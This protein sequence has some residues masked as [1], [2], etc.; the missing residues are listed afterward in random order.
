M[1]RKFR[2][3]KDE[4]EEHIECEIESA[5]NHLMHRMY[6]ELR[7]TMDYAVQQHDE[8]ALLE[9]ISRHEVILENKILIEMARN[10]FNIKKEVKK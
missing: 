3:L 6:N 10:A 9:L 1:D 4:L 5:K 2:E 8:A 7:A